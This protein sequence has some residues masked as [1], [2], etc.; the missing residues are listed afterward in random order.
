MSD[1]EILQTCIFFNDRMEAMPSTSGW[2][3]GRYCRDRFEECA[4][5]RVY[6]TLGRP[7]VPVDLFPTQ[8]QRALDLIDA[9]AETAAPGEP[10]PAARS[11][12]KPPLPR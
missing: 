2:L 11:S 10:G 8:L 6:K 5:Y 9:A 1:C 7:L 12:V 4:R 3:K